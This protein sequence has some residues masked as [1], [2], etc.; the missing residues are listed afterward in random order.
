MG[1]NIQKVHLE[2]PF[3]AKHPSL[4]TSGHFLSEGLP[5]LPD[6]EAG[7]VSRV[8][9]LS[10]LPQPPHPR[11]PAGTASLGTS[12]TGVIL[13][14]DL[15]FYS[16]DDEPAESPRHI[17]ADPLLLGILSSVILMVPAAPASSLPLVKFYLGHSWQPAL[18]RPSCSCSRTM[19]PNPA[20][21]T[22]KNDLSLTRRKGLSQSS[23]IA[24]LPYQGV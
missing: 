23:S 19:P 14:S 6:R 13:E 17:P 16:D 4:L 7:P 11:F 22:P 24:S 20:F 18:S 3:R 21:C 9:S 1:E 5:W 12:Q 8:P 2:H 15:H 10:Q